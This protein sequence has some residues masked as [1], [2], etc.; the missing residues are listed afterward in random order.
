MKI[1]YRTFSLLCIF[2]ISIFLK[3]DIQSEYHIPIDAS[4][5]FATNIFHD[6]FNDIIVGHE[7]GWGEPFPTITIM[8]NISYGSFEITDTSKS[9]CGYQYNIFAIDV[10]NDGWADIV[11][12]HKDFSTGTAKNY[13]RIYYNDNGTFPNDN[14]ADFNLNSS[15]IIDGINYGDINGDGNIDLVISSADD[16]FWGVL[17]NNGDGSFT[18][19]IYYSFNSPY[20]IVCGDLNGDGRDDVV[21]CGMDTK[22]YFSYSSGFQVLTLDPFAY[23]EDPIIVDFDLDGKKDIFTEKYIWQYDYTIVRM[24]KNLGNNTFQQLTDLIYPGAVGGL[25]IADF[26]NDGYPDVLFSKVGGDVIWYNQ[27]NFQLTDSQFVAI[28]N[29]GEQFVNVF[30]A[31]LDNNAF[32]DIITVRFDSYQNYPNL[33]IRFNDGHGHFGRDPIVGVQNDQNNLS[34]NL[35]NYPNPF[36]DE[37]I[38]EFNSKETALVDLSV[39]DL[40]GKFITCLVNQKMEGGTHLIKWRGL[41]NGDQPCKP[42]VFIAYLKVNGKISHAIK[43]IKT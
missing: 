39:F 30:L 14:Y 19:P 21:V 29:Y 38:F 1:F 22:V 6:G 26:N 5:V 4:S 18:P 31:D 9:F 23:M 10:N 27:G 8:K 33:D 35:K 16:N 34:S 13:I 17:Y 11:T 24:F 7:T 2:L 36:Q 28:P 43:V 42:G 3:E 32:N 25:H 41:D 40:Q 15:A 20:D 37:T 12:F